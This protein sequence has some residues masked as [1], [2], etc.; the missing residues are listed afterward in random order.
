M[1]R[2]SVLKLNSSYLRQFQ[3]FVICSGNRTEIAMSLSGLMLLNSVYQMTL[4]E[5]CCYFFQLG[6]RMAEFPVEPTMSKMLIASE[7]YVK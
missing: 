1:A 7:K 3:S 2:I 4:M 6:R 5:G